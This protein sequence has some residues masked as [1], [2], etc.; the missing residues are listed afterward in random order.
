MGDIGRDGGGVD[1][2]GF[3]RGGGVVAIISDDGDGGCEG[4]ESD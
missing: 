4:R 2:G 1:G 3:T